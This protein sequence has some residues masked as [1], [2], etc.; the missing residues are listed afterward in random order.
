MVVQ[1]RTTLDS[2]SWTWR[3]VL[4]RLALVLGLGAVA[5]A[6]RAVARLW[7]DSAP[8]A[9]LEV[10]TWVSRIV[11]VLLAIR[12]GI[13]ADPRFRRDAV[14]ERVDRFLA[15]RWPSLVVDSLLLLVVFVLFSI[16]EWAA[17]GLQGIEEDRYWAALL[18]VKNLTVIP[19][20]FLWVVS[21]AR[22]AVLYESHVPSVRPSGV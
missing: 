9:L 3:F 14:G 20:T 19:L 18:A 17:S 10:V 16:P 7:E 11:L 12:I 1:L 15:E 13:L 6:S 2:L 22:Q 8:V 21:V 4:S 5:G